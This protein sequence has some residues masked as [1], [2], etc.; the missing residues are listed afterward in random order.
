MVVIKLFVQMGYDLHKAAPCVLNSKTNMKKQIS[1][2]SIGGGFEFASCA[3]KAPHTKPSSAISIIFKTPQSL[4]EIW[5]VL[6]K[7]L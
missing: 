1:Q 6:P 5:A 7:S 3:S 2:R 4:K